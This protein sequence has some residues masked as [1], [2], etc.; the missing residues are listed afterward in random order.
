MKKVYMLKAFKRAFTE[1]EMFLPKDLECP[2]N[3]CQGHD[4][5]VKLLAS[6]LGVEKEFQDWVKKYLGG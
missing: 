4:D 2:R 1:T 5:A 3:Y 6:L